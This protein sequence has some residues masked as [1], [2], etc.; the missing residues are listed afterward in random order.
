MELR[1]GYKNTEVGIIPTDWEVIDFGIAA[2][3]IIGGGTP[4]RSNSNYWGNEIPWVTV[5]D[6][7]TFN[8]SYTQEYITKEGLKNSASHLIPKGTI[9]TSTRMA[10]GKA[11]IYDVDVSINQDLKAIIPKRNIDTI[12]LYHWFQ[13]NS[14]F[15]EDL[16]SGSTVMGLSLPDLK[17]I[18]VKLPATKVEQTLI[19]NVLSDVDSL[20][21]SLEKIIEKKRSIRQGTIQKLLKPKSHWE[22]KKLAE[23]ANIIGG[24]TPS[25][26]ITK[27]WN[28][29]INWFTPTEI[30]KNKYTYESVRKITKEGFLNS[31]GKMLPVG[32]ILLTS[33]AGIG[34]VSILMNESCTNQG[35]QSLVPKE[36]YNSEYL[37]YLLLTLK[38]VLLQ[39]ASGST[40]LEI[41][42]T[43]IKQIEV[44]MPAIEEQ[45]EIAKIL[46]DI[47]SEIVG[48]ETKLEK[49]RK[50]KLGI[51]QNLLTGKIRLV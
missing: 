39:N 17:K 49:Y 44:A 48:L 24:G 34:D 46:S 37:Y 51:M 10:L 41:S 9:I 6:F 38:N 7:A 21:N 42:P 4:S 23:I 11:V 28:G 8:S 5:K 35:F 20:L 47:D 40:F 50:V 33:R 13:F 25:T 15:I 45:E 31:S 29:T 26:F 16:G 14:K 30:G 22:I 3:K 43:K 2:E 19:A 1:A 18:K 36:G 32:T 12:F 27:Y